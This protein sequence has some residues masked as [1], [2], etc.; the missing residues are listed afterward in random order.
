MTADERKLNDCL[1]ALEALRNGM[2]EFKANFRELRIEDFTTKNGFDL[3]II[4]KEAFRLYD[5]LS[6]DQVE[7]ISFLSIKLIRKKFRTSFD[8]VHAYA[9]FMHMNKSFTYFLSNLDKKVQDLQIHLTISNTKF[10]SEIAKE[11]VDNKGYRESFSV[12]AVRK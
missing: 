11:R 12:R 4:M 6:E 10:S 5:D 8:K 3:L 9:F 1:I 2:T 7:L